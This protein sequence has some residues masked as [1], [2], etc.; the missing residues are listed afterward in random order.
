MAIGDKAAAAGLPLVAGTELANTLDTIENETR[1]MIGEVK[2]SQAKRVR[3]G[4]TLPG[5]TGNVVGEIF[6]R[7]S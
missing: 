4:T 6:V 3:V 7:Y 5:T 2:L 1:D